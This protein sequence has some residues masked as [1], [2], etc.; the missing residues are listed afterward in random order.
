MLTISSNQFE[1]ANQILE[2]KETSNDVKALSDIEKINQMLD[3]LSKFGYDLTS[4]KKLDER[5]RLEYPE[6]NQ[7]CMFNLSND[8][9]TSQPVT[10]GADVII[11]KDRLN[12]DK[13]GILLSVLIKHKRISTIQ[14]FVEVVR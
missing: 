13:F 5:L 4:A 11:V 10:Y 1:I 3:C 7:L 14:D 6:I 12:T 8:G 2:V 9:S